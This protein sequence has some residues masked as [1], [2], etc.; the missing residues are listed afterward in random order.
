MEFAAPHDVAFL[1]TQAFAQGKELRF[2]S[3]ADDLTTI[4]NV[5][6]ELT[7]GW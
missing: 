3:S 5:L 1:N 7:S 2:T 4:G 6:E